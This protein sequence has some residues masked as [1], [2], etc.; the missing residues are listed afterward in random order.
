MSELILGESARTL[1]ERFRLS[2]PA[3]LSD[4]LT[5]DDVTDC[6]LAKEQPGCLSLW[7]VSTWESKLD[8]AVALVS[9]KIV[10]GR[11]EGRLEQVQL[12]GRLLST[13]HTRVRL[14]G[15]RR[16]ALPEG[17]REFLG[18]EPGDTVM[19]I[20]AAICIE[21]WDPQRWRQHIADQMPEFRKLMDDLV[22]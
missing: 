8:E 16:I 11:L 14:A 10:A 22:G 2:L 19:V 12:F 6:I 9:R 13:R 21:I 3:E 1:D 20:G 4:P 17:F 18:V 15:R 7:D 5:T